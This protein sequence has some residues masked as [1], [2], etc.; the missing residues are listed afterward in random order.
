MSDIRELLEAV[1]DLVI[2]PVQATPGAG[3]TQLVG[4]QG[5]AGDDCAPF[6]VPADHVFVMGD[7][8]DES[9]DSRFWGPVPIPDIKGL[10]MVNYWSW[11]GENW[12]RWSRLGH[13][14]D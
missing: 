14:V 6:T 12:V 11:G 1:D 4:R 3:R 7:N 10:A 9:F 5:D 13:L 2:V 8:R